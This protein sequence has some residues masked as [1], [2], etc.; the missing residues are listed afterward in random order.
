MALAF[1]EVK[2]RDDYYRDLHTTDQLV[3]NT[4]ERH[5]NSY[6]NLGFNSDTLS[7]YGSKSGLYMTPHGEE[8]RY[9][10]Y[11]RGTVGSARHNYYNLVL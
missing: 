2:C 11:S 8:D 3:Y 4:T 6:S 7:I 5:L 9:S 1:S 10:A